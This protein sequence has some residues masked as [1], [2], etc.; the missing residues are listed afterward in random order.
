MAGRNSFEDELAR[1]RRLRERQAVVQEPAEAE[2]VAPPASAQPEDDD[3]LPHFGWKDILAMCIA[4]YQIIFPILL[5]LVGV[6]FV[7]FLLFRL[8]FH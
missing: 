7:A 1:R 4:A 3:E 2:R 8:Y 5:L 6:M